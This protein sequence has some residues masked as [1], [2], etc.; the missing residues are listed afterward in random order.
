[1][2]SYVPQIDKCVLAALLSHFCFLLTVLK[3]RENSVKKMY[4]SETDL[5]IYFCL[6]RFHQS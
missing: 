2:C 5:N 6:I 1:M 3:T 4:V